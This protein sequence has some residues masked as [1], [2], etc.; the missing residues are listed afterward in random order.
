MGVRLRLCGDLI[1]AN[2]VPPPPPPGRPKAGNMGTYAIDGLP[3]SD[4]AGNSYSIDVNSPYRAD[5]VATPP[6]RVLQATSRGGNQV[7]KEWVRTNSHKVLSGA[8]TVQQTMI[9]AQRERIH[10]L[11]LRLFDRDAQMKLLSFEH[12]FETKEKEHFPDFDQAFQRVDGPSDNEEDELTQGGDGVEDDESFEKLNFSI[13]T[14]AHLHGLKDFSTAQDETADLVR[15]QELLEVAQPRLSVG[16]PCMLDSGRA[17]DKLKT[18]LRPNADAPPDL[19]PTHRGARAIERASMGSEATDDDDMPMATLYEHAV[20]ATEAMEIPGR[21]STGSSQ[22]THRLSIGS[23]ESFGSDASDKPGPD[24]F[25]E[26][27]FPSM[28]PVK[29][30]FRSQKQGAVQTPGLSPIMSGSE[31]DNTRSDSFHSMNEHSGSKTPPTRR[32]LLFDENNSPI[33]Q[34]ER[35][36]P[37]VHPAPTHSAVP[38]TPGSRGKD[39]AWRGSR[40]LQKFSTPGLSPILDVDSRSLRLVERQ[41]SLF[42]D[43]NASLSESQRPL[44]ELSSLHEPSA[45]AG[46]LDDQSQTSADPLRFTSPMKESPSTFSLNST[47]ND[48]PDSD[49]DSAPRRTPSMLDKI[50]RVR[51]AQNYGAYLLEAESFGVKDVDAQ[52]DYARMIASRGENLH[53]VSNRRFRFDKNCYES[54]FS[55]TRRSPPSEFQVASLLA[56]Q[57]QNESFARGSFARGSHYWKKKLSIV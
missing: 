46:L 52:W 29:H 37:S 26:A 24:Q 11:E 1:M 6:R 8:D 25:Q 40:F 16:R 35:G 19:S 51:D 9:N 18:P 12:P 41:R 53:R 10:E 50:S 56:S 47:A 54:V 2:S 3:S 5:A 30:P 22:P 44:Q 42:L 55:G 23:R 21:T 33:E 32:S 17:I 7:M 14:L 38:V 48:P 36:S 27:D 49:S 43:S 34:R 15:Q 4:L 13:D 57:A 28:T 45:A 20:M 31:T 39:K